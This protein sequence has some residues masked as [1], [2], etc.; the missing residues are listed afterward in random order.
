V[1]DGPS[2]VETQRSRPGLRTA[3]IR[4]AAGGRRAETVMLI[5]LRFGETGPDISDFDA[6]ADAV[7]ALQTVGLENEAKRLVLELAAT[8]GL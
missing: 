4:A 6:V 3:I 8:A 1:L 7:A 5:L 2:I